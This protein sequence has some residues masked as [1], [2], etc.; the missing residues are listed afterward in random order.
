MKRSQLEPIV[1]PPPAVS[2]QPAKANRPS[3]PEQEALEAVH[4]EVMGNFGVHRPDIRPSNLP[5]QPERSAF[6]EIEDAPQPHDN[7]D[8]MSDRI[9]DAMVMEYGRNAVEQTYFNVSNPDPPANYGAL[10]DPDS[11]STAHANRMLQ[12]TSHR[13]QNEVQQQ[14]ARSNTANNPAA[15]GP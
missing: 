13:V 9:V 5:Q 7:A 2:A 12:N 3:N 4:Q 11:Q 10:I 8:V 6:E 1:E 15:Q 14:L